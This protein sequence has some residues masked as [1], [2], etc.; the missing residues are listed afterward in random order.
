MTVPACK[1]LRNAGQE[2]KFEGISLYFCCCCQGD[3]C[4][5]LKMK[6]SVL[7]TASINSELV[8]FFNTE[9]CTLLTSELY[10]IVFF[11]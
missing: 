5:Y 1:L 2:I 10:K 8:I 9:E 4:L 11:F 7:T 3:F 6:K